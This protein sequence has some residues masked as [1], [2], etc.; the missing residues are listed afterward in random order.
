MKFP[1]PDCCSHLIV[2]GLF[3]FLNLLLTW[4]DLLKFADMQIVEFILF[5]RLGLLILPLFYIW[6]WTLFISFLV[7]CLCCISYAI[8]P[9][10]LIFL[11]E[12]KETGKMIY[13]PLLTLNT[14]VSDYLQT[15]FENVHSQSVL[16][17]VYFLHSWCEWV[18]HTKVSVHSSSA[19]VC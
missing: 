5:W 7:L 16:N 9:D 17:A 2:D 11:L 6:R 10:F 4:S 13:F 12:D 19:V 15:V 18:Y 3:Y 14:F 1:L 8:S